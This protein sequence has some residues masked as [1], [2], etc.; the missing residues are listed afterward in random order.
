[1]KRKLII[2][3]FAALC[4]SAAPAMAD[5][6]GTADVQYLGM[7]RGMTLNMTAHN[8]ADGWVTGDM[9]A[10]L[11]NLDI[12][13]LSLTG[14]QTIPSDSYLNQGYEQAFCTDIWDPYPQPDAESYSVMSLDTTPDPVAAPVGGMGDLKAKLIAELLIEN[15]YTTD[16]DAAAVQ[17]AIWEI[18]QESVGSWDVSNGN[19]LYYLGTGADEIAV[20]TAAND[21]LAGLSSIGMSYD[22]YTA[23]SNGG[24]KQSQDFVV[25]P[26]PAAVLLGI[27]GLSVAGIK[28][29]KYA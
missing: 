21:M 16:L 13:N 10:G 17:V 11:L 5:L 14:P 22:R 23:L 19:G 28:L 6:Y 9:D 1:M 24:F 12:T 4:L 2:L 7:L 18:L 20:A 26:V 29:R 25:V 27:L 8:P 15:T 3:C